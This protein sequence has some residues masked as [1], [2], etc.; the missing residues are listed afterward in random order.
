MGCT[1]GG[2]RDARMV[3][4]DAGLL[5]SSSARF[6]TQTRQGRSDA[7]HWGVPKHLLWDPF[8]PLVVIILPRKVGLNCEALSCGVW[9]V[10]GS[11][12]KGMFALCV[13]RK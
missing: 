1:R 5:Y 10:V 11:V 2:G 7:D 12:L 6:H 3:F 4:S 13:C 8:F 9:C